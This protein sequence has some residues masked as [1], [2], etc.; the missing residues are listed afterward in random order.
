M[1]KQ[2][3]IIFIVLSSIFCFSSC[4]HVRYVTKKTTLDSTIVSVKSQYA[5]Q[6]FLSTGRTSDTKNE[7]V[8]AGISY[9]GKGGYGTAMANQY[10]TYDSY[11]FADTLGN[12]MNYSVKYKLYRTMEG[13]LYVENVGVSSY[14]TDNPLYYSQLF[15]SDS[16]LKQINNL[17][18]DLALR[19][20]DNEKTLYLCSG[21]LGGLCLIALL[22]IVIG[23]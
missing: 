9:S 2:Y 17:P 11:S 18:K 22:C 23:R 5:K 21:I 16:P 6:G 20:Y 10:I 1:R 4:T 12:T 15:G 3:S 8:V 19:E 13:T 7:P 14:E